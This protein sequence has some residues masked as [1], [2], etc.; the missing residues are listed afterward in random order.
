MHFR[1]LLAL[2]VFP[3]F[4]LAQSVTIGSGSFGGSNV[5]GPMFS[6][7]SIDT[8][9]SRQAYIYPSSVLSGLKHGDSISSIEFYAQAD[10]PMTGNP[11]LKIYLK[12]VKIDTF[13]TGNINWTNESKSSGMVLVYDA[14][15]IAIM[16]GNSGYKNFIFN[17][18]KFRFDT[19]GGK[20]NLEILFAYNQTARQQSGTFWLYESNFTVSAFKSRN[21]GKISYGSG[22]AP[23]TTRGSDVRKPHL[24]INFPRYQNN[25][26]VLISYCLGKVPL[27]AGVNDSIKVIIG[28]RGKGEVKNAKLYLDISGANSHRDS[29]VVGSLKPWEDKLYG[30]GTYKPDSAGTDDIIISL[31]RDDDNSN[32]FDSLKREINYNIFSHADPFKSNAGGIGFNGSTGDFVAKFFS[33]TGVYINQVSVDF[34]SAGR[35]FRVGI[36]DDDASGGFPG[37][38]LF[39]SDSLTSKGGTYILPVLPRVKVSGGFF[40]GIRQNTNNNVAFSFQDE[41]PIRPGAFYFTAPMGN[42]SW[43]PFS[44][45]FPYKFNIQPR[46]QVA[47]DVAPI[48]IIYPS[49]NQDIDYS[50]KDSLGPRATVVNYGFNNQTTP[51]EVECV[52]KNAAGT[53]EYTSTKKITLNAGQSKTVYF[54]TTYRLY[55]LGDHRISVTTKLANDKVV[56]NNFLEQ[57]FKISVKHDIG[58]DFMYSP[59]EGTTFEYKRDT[60]L[61]TV[62]IVNY[63]TVAKN[64]FR[65]TFSIKNDTSI[66]HSETITKSLAAGKQE[67]ISFKKYLPITVG[68]Y[69]AECFTTLKDSIPFNDT[70]RHN[71]TFQKSNDV[72]PKKI[73]I[74]LPTSIYTMGGFFF[75]KLV[76]KNYGHKTQ[77]TAFKVEVSVYGTQGQLIFYDSLYTQLGGYSET[78]VTFKRCNI[79]MTFGKYKIFYR[80]ALIGDQETSN[81]TLSGY[82]TVIP[83]RDIGVSQILVPAM[84]SIISIESLPFKPIIRIKNFGSLTLSSAGPTILKIYKGLNLVYYDSAFTGGNLSYNSS[85]NIAFNKSFTNTQLGDYTLVA[86]TK[87][88]GDL[89]SANDTF[90]T[91]R[92][93]ITRN[94]DLALDTISNFS[95]GHIFVYEK[96]YFMPQILVKNFGSKSYPGLYS[97]RLDLFKNDT[98]FKTITRIFD[99]LPK[100]AT[101][102]WFQD[103]L[104]NLRQVG[105]FRLC[106]KIT[107][108]L[109]QRNSNDSFCWNFSIIK[110]N[111]LAL[112]SIMFPDKSNQCYNNI[113]YQPKIKATNNGSMAIVN[114]SIQ[115]RIYQTTN[116][117]W[118]STRFVDLAPSESKWIKFDSSLSFDFTG[119]AWARAVGELSDDNEKDNDTVIRD[120]KVAFVSG[121]KDMNR[122]SIVAYPN[123]TSEKLII[124]LT[125]NVFQQVTIFTTS[126][127]KVYEKEFKPTERKIELDLKSDLGLKG[128]VYYLRLQNSYT[129]HLIK[130]ILY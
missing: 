30:F 7:N 8:A 127:Q 45:G 60:I 32:N 39:M 58:A 117:I 118:E 96:S 18:N 113:K 36:W 103:S 48:A 90:K 112:D 111:D 68:D 6:T 93:R 12:M 123:P 41:D 79:P 49:S 38:V 25:L 50:I 22:P 24:R 82:F 129:S 101:N 35:G 37:K 77:D 1:F 29:I 81:D 74:P 105:K 109:D 66:I 42:T 33:D 21:E 40:V 5:Y 115:F 80:T 130:L 62:R 75:P 16:D 104:I 63:G 26:G 92:F 59:D 10:L 52:I 85:F 17:L 3:F 51:F 28:N 64:N 108:A 125:Y 116:I 54:D 44:P 19:S 14:N 69:V 128:G 57:Q 100:S 23:D 9:F 87:L 120:F 126:G 43:I 46:I 53:T 78:Q 83:N 70:I 91:S 65:V 31:S 4:G 56:D 72:S 102:S 84:D 76:V 13:P 11:N 61:P 122:H 34:S 89:V 27:L 73:D 20:K 124:D 86:Y 119:T 121:I 47:N 97:V 15:P 94:Y 55:N 106:A 114:T 98:I 95:N 2:L 110:P 71:V 67:I 88:T 107:G 99:S